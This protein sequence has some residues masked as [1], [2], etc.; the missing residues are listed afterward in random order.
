MDK[1]EYK[2]RADEIKELLAQ[3]NYV[4]AAEI[5]DTIDWRRVK[6]VMMLCM[7]SDLY[8]FN[9]R[10]EDAKNILLLAY[11]RRPGGRTICYSLCEMCIKT[12]DFLQAVNYYKEYVQAAP[13]D[14]G[15][16]ILQYKL[17]EAQDVGLEERIGVL[18]ELKKRDY[19]EKWAYELAYLYHRVG[20]ATRCVEEC[21]E[22]ILWFGEGKYVV[23]AMELK[24]LHEPLTPMQQQKYDHRFD[25]PIQEEMSE[26]EQWLEESQGQEAE[27]WNVANQFQ[28][29]ELGGVYGSALEG[30]QWGG[31]GS[32]Q[33]EDRWE[34]YGKEKEGQWDADSQAQEEGQWGVNSGAQEEGQWEAYGRTQEESQWDIYGQT[35]GNDQWSGEG[36]IQRQEPWE[37]GAG[38]QDAG[39]WEA[40]EQ[41]GED[42]SWNQSGGQIE[43][44]RQWEGYGQDIE[45]GVD[46]S[47]S[48]NRNGEDSKEPEDDLDI[49]VKT[50]DVSQ[51][52]TINLQAE[53]AAGLQEILG[54]EEAA[55]AKDMESSSKYEECQEAD[56][57]TN[58]K[59]EECREADTETN[60]KYEECRE[61]DTE[62]N[63]KYEECRE[64]D[65][66]TSAKYEE[67]README[68]NAKYEYEECQ[69]ADMETNV[70]YE[71]EECQEADMETNVKYEELQ[72][73]DTE[74]PAMEDA[75]AEG[76]IATE[77]FM[78]EEIEGQ[79][80]GET[81]PWLEDG[82]YADQ[83]PS[84]EGY[85]Q[86]AELFVTE[87]L[88]DA[89]VHMEAMEASNAA[90]DMETMGE[91][92]TGPHM[93][94]SH[95]A[96]G[97]SYTGGYTEVEAIS[98]VGGYDEGSSVSNIGGQVEENRMP[99]YAP[100]QD[101]VRDDTAE[102]V[103]AQM[104][105]ESLGLLQSQSQPLR[106]EPNEPT[107]KEQ[108]SEPPR[109]E[110][111]Q[112]DIMMPESAMIEK[113]ITGQMKI[114]DILAEW[115]QTKKDNQEKYK[116]EIRQDVLRQTGPMF[117]EF[118][119][120]VRDSLLAQ[121]EKDNQ[122]A[123]ALEE[124]D[125]DQNESGKTDKMISMEEIRRRTAGTSKRN[126]N[127]GK[128]GN[129]FM[130]G[131][132]DVGEN[133]DT[134]EGTQIRG[135]QAK[136]EEIRE[137]RLET[138]ESIERREAQTDHMGEPRTAVEEAGMRRADITEGETRGQSH[139]E[140][141]E[142]GGQTHDQAPQT[143]IS[144]AEDQTEE[145]TQHSTEID[146]TGKEQDEGGL[147]VE[148]MEDYYGSEAHKRAE[149][150]AV[151]AEG[152]KG[153]EEKSVSVQSAKT[154]GKRSREA[155]VE[156]KG[157]STE[158]E[159]VKIRGLT[160]EEKELYAPFIQSRTAREKLVQA[161]DN[162]SMAAYTGNIV[163]T[164]EEGMDTMTFAK[165]M[166]R[167]VQM[168]DS[169]FSGKVAKIS[170]E[171]LNEREINET[172]WHL[173][174]GALIIYHASG[175][176][177]RTAS[178]L[179]KA[180]QQESLGIIV[181]LEDTKKAIQKMFLG[182]PELYHD[183]TA[184]M[185]LEALSNDTLVAFGKRYA[186]EKEYSIDNMG[187]LALHTRIE[188]LQT[189][190]HVVTVVEVK[191][192]VDAAI[193]HACRKTPGHFF[194]ILFARRYDAEDMIILTEKDFAY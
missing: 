185:D 41:S 30:N 84:C 108:D 137:R 5:A 28:G 10:Y 106:Q 181:V 14:P 167:E 170:G 107:A 187:V 17:Y 74:T 104:R 98:E 162:I 114:E 40:M 22:L 158:R 8:K 149:A 95:E 118:E 33:A 38:V 81:E 177:T 125:L 129:G 57:E 168:T 48:D 165:N 182:T 103:L 26:D 75:A 175:M 150:A 123:G 161:I 140:K 1:Y 146:E 101:L 173:N 52:N 83:A 61:A 53:L 102:L 46:G 109:E 18:E 68:T 135:R 100:E 13:K 79:R 96:D 39:Q 12:E 77:I 116:E 164:G 67:C 6:S 32:T 62:T 180:L 80:A 54:A 119:A 34:A 64:A 42:E 7:I 2:I 166:I 63:A 171:S 128:T 11:E 183:F 19:R 189:I 159:K 73:A 169:N 188:E 131:S 24:M 47:I 70:K 9:R 141:E 184:R 126:G 142:L 133:Q 124:I 136:A 191:K 44:E 16:Y 190:D 152:D 193:R 45:S 4:Q 122:G 176:D 186:R 55:K 43:N 148:S 174:N 147:W 163:I 117:T 92:D 56:T 15:R 51:Y 134:I 156:D 120:S 194:D 69:E 82:Q 192:I 132:G 105:L 145:Y 37:N 160:R 111:R 154:A 72:E 151:S 139:E 31:S 115:E 90:G 65:M 50:M 94:T 112:S 89:G 21:D 85:E 76:T 20:L 157:A 71:Y 113:Q 36:L 172:L 110:D 93:E 143:R 29:A 178:S 78:E 66:E 86:A 23:K 153:A 35:Q 91:S 130:S 58:A 49:Q 127:V 88:A 99:A 97:A 144:A 60:A 121:L 155:A 59:Y 138:E 27:Q 25:E 179:H 87:E 3:E